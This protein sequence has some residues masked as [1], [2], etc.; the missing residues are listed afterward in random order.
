LVHL[1][2]ITPANFDELIRLQVGSGQEAY[3]S[4]VVHSLAQAWVYRDTA[5]PFAVYADDIPVGF[6]MLGYYAQRQQYTLWKF[7]ID[8]KYQGKGYGRQALQLAIE[9][10]VERFAAREIY[11]GVSIGNEAARHL[12][13]SV[14][15]VPTGL[16]EDHMEEMKYVCAAP[17]RQAACKK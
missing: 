11:T 7:L 12:Y 3:V 2:P 1:K 6:V 10:L 15:F 5:F 14:G 9:Y 16:V 4:S 8:Q 17:D 13:A